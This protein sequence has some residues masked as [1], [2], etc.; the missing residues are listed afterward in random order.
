MKILFTICAR[1]GSK[2]I[3]N[4]NIINFCG[5]P[6]VYYT[7]AA[8]KLFQAEYSEIFQAV[9]VAVNTDS[10]ELLEQ[11]NAVG[12]HYQ[13]VKRVETLAGDAVSK[14][15]VIKDTLEKV[16]KISNKEYDIVVDLD[17]TSPLRT[18]AD[19]KGTIDT[20][21]AN[22]KADIAFSVTEARR[23]PYFN[24]VCEKEDG[25]FNTVISSEFVARQEV[26]VCFDMNASIYAYKREY[27][28]SGRTGDRNAVI[29][30]MIDTA[31]LDIDTE[32]DLE[33]L[34]VL[35]EYFWEK[36]AELKRIKDHI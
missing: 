10:K 12:I 33:L 28:L 17:L 25:Y 18:V 16:E 36:N 29:W 3:K 22:E 30:K 7:V 8:L 14:I 20:V 24:M 5:N 15:S 26:P 31:V 1:A 4:K 35:A 6:L 2:G 19:I 27:I 23:S 9:D 11:L 13:Y 21:L 34:E 32:K